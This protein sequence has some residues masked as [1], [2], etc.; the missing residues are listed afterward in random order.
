MKY[1]KM[2]GLAAMAAMALM[3]FVGAGTASATTLEDSKGVHPTTISASLIGSAVLSNP[4]ETSTYDTCTEGTVHGE[5]ST[6]SATETVKG[7]A[8]VSFVTSSCT[9]TTH[10]TEGGNLEIHHIAKTVNGTV[11]GNTFKVQVTIF[12]VPCTYGL[13]KTDTNVHVGTLTGSDTTPLMDINTIVP[14]R[15][16]GFLCPGEARWKATYEVTTPSSLTVTAG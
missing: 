16:G 4:A 5:P 11:T 7:A 12:G 9:S 15:E 8:A 10:A 3:A 1:I 13:S 14:L 2:L 6:C